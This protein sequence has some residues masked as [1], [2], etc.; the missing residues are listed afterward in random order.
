MQQNAMNAAAV[1]NNARTADVSTTDGFSFDKIFRAKSTATAVTETKAL[2]PGV[3]SAVAQADALCAS[4]SQLK[5]DVLDRSD[6]ALWALLEQVYAYIDSVAGTESERDTRVELIKAIKMRGKD[7]VSTSAAL[8]AAVVRYVFADVSRQ[9]CSNYTL[10]MRKAKALKIATNA[11]ANFLAENGGVSKVLEKDFAYETAARE[12]SAAVAKAVREAKESRTA[13]VGRLYSVMAQTAT[14]A[15]EYDGV[16]ADWVLE[17]QVKEGKTA[18]KEEKPDPKYERGNFVLFVTVQN[19]DTGKYHVV[20]GNV[21]DRA[22]E[23]QL[24]STIAER[25]GADTQELQQVVAGMEQQQLAA[26]LGQAE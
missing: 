10:A 6:R 9:T 7:G 11:F 8:D 4:Y 3:K 16:V 25:M 14:T 2:T 5:V 18:G 17:K 24:L 23:A 21:F 1:M 15:I 22:F 26:Q 12:D 20:Q 13:L 19:P